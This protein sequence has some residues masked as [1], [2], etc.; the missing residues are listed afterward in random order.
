MRSLFGLTCVFALCLTPIFGCSESQQQEPDLEWPPNATAYFDQYGI[1]HADCAFDEDCAM[2]LG[3]FHAAD[4]FVQMELKR[5]LPTGRLTEIM[6]KA[7]AELF[8]TSALDADSRALFSSRDGR[9]FEDQFIEGLSDETRAL[10]EAYTA[11]VNQWIDNV[12]TGREGAVFPREFEGF[13][14]DYSA[15]EIPDWTIEDSAA[16]ALPVLD[17]LTRQLAEEVAAGTAR[18]EIGDDAKFDDLWTGRPRVESSILPPGWTP[19]AAEAKQSVVAAKRDTSAGDSLDAGSAL[20][21]LSARMKA[22]QAIRNALLGNRS[23]SSS[24]GSNSWVIGPSRT[25]SGHAIMANDAHL[26]MSQPAIWYLAHLD[27]KTHGRGKLHS[28]GATL[29]GL[30]SV[31][32]GQNESIAWG[33]TTLFMD[34]TDW[35]I[36]E[37]VTDGDGNPT[38]VMFEGRGV[39]FERVPFTVTFNDGTEEQHEL[40]FVP[41]HG[42]VRE[43]DPDNKVAI[44]LRWTAQDATTDINAFSAIEAA[45]SVEEAKVAMENSTAM[46]QCWVVADVE[47]NIGYFPYNRPPKRTWATNLAGDAPPWVPLDGRCM[48]PERCYEWTEFFDYAELPQVVNPE[49]GYVATANN[50][51]TGSLFDGDPTNDGYPPLQTD[52]VP[53][54]RHA[55]IVEMMDDLGSGHSPETSRQMQGDVQS[56]VGKGEAPGFIAIAESDETNLSARA[57]KVLNALKAWEFTCPTGLDG[58]YV[59]SPLADDPQEL[60]E[61]SGCSAIHALIYNCRPLGLRKDYARVKSYAYYF[62]VIDPTRLNLGDAYWDD[63][64]TP[65]TETKYQTI[66]Q[67]FDDAA[68]LLIDDLGLGDDETK[69]AWGRAQRLVLTSDLAT[70]GVTSHDNPPP[71]ETP[72]TNAG[73]LWTVSPTDPGLDGDGFFQTLGASN[74]FVCEALPSGPRCTVQLPGGQSSHVDSPNYDDLLFKWLDNEPIDLVFD[75]DEAK[76]SAVRTVTFE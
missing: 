53:G 30:P 22:N 13:P 56:G 32:V 35:Y 20:R 61:A 65:E 24:P 52:V 23:V 46:P 74:R 51:I 73:G 29:A 39:P 66:E 57:Q 26:A 44:T 19:P 10:F 45:T 41:H 27:A 69:W 15:S 71:G 34:V 48:T 31:V 42:P 12:R 75:I 21:R 36:E 50:D 16:T 38:G 14:F 8:E 72:F 5:R 63:P 25:E 68:A 47:G 60:R 76:A 17:Q 2:V 37:L 6:D 33:S 7:F 18:Q 62:S 58:K 28:A 49:Q 3:Y 59:D 40:L 55:R 43:I 64:D 11:G 9:P 70:F 54:F 1:L 4:R 67:C